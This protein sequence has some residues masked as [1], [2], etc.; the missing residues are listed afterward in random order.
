M[1][2]LF[3]WFEIDPLSILLLALLHPVHNFF[4]TFLS[5][6][7]IFIYIEII[8]ML[9]RSELSANNLAYFFSILDADVLQVLT[10]GLLFVS[11]VEIDCIVNQLHQVCIQVYSRILLLF[12]LI[13]DLLHHIVM[14]FIVRAL[15]CLLLDE[16]RCVSSA[17]LANAPSFSDHHGEFTEFFEVAELFSMLF[18][19]HHCW[20]LEK[21]GV[22][23]GQIDCVLFIFW[24]GK[25]GELVLDGFLEVL[26]RNGSIAYFS[27]P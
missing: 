17:L 24:S 7:L 23:V 6:L 27:L 18:C 22:S 14:L 25:E 11:L 5:P 1:F 9:V 4:H 21:R 8:F 19:R 12:G 15:F 16:L 26:R 20:L 10:E 13:V 3:G 2:F